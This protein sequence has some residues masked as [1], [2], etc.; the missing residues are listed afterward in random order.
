MQTATAIDFISHSATNLADAGGQRTKLTV[1][2][3]VRNQGP[4]HVAGITYTSDFWRT[5]REQLATFQRF[6]GNREIWHLEA[7][8]G[9]NDAGFEYVIFCRDYRGVGGV[10]EIYDTNHGQ[11]YQ[12]KGH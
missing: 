5:P 12:I 4:A 11:T 1:D 7:V 3:A 8:V 10:A 6:E 9:G 2:F